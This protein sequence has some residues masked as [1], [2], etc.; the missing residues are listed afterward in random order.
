MMPRP[1]GGPIWRR[2]DLRQVLWMLP[3]HTLTFTG[4]TIRGVAIGVLR[5]RPTPNSEQDR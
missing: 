5:V 4:L 3:N 2:M 1:H